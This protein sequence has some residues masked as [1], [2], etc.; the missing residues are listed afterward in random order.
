MPRIEHHGA[1]PQRV[2]RVERRRPPDLQE[3]VAAVEAYAVPPDPRGQVE[4]NRHFV[5]RRL[6]VAHA[7]HQR[8]GAAVLHPVHVGRDPVETHR[9]AALVFR[10]QVRHAS[11]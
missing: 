10:H 3:Q 6:R 9:D 1:G 8:I 11:G 5:G 7:P 2:V 4:R